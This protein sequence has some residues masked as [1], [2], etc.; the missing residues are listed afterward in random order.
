ML[1]LGKTESDFVLTIKRAF[2]FISHLSTNVF[3]NMFIIKELL[4]W[5][6]RMPAEFPLCEVKQKVVTVIKQMF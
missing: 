4:D 2:N 6:W 1:G 3:K 5:A